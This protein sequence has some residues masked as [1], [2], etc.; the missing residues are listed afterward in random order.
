VVQAAGHKLPSSASAPTTI[1]YQPVPAVDNPNTLKEN[2]EVRSEGLGS[3]ES[4]VLNLVEAAGP[5]LLKIYPWE[6][7][8]RW[9]RILLSETWI[10]DRDSRG[11][12]ENLHRWAGDKRSAENQRKCN[13]AYRQHAQRCATFSG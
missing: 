4:D 7:K 5:N 1:Y 9:A 11:G 3:G 10:S 2:L 6:E 13:V 8:A 12:R